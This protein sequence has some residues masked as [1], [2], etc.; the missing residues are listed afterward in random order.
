MLKFSK[1]VWNKEAYFNL[2][3]KENKTILPKRFQDCPDVVKE[4]ALNE[5]LLSNAY[6][7]HTFRDDWF[8]EYYSHLEDKFKC[9]GFC[10]TTYYN[11][12]TRSNSKIVK[13][14]FTDYTRGIPEHFGCL[15]SMMDWLRKTLNAF[16][17]CGIF[18]FVFEMV[19]FVL[20]CMMLCNKEVK[21]KVKEKSKQDKQQEED[22]AILKAR[23]MRKEEERQKKLEKEE[24]ERKRKEEEE[25]KKK[26]QENQ[27]MNTSYVPPQSQKNEEDI[28]FNPSKV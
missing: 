27:L 20:G 13:Y 1:E 14:L 2:W 16:A 8:Q 9:T 10:G 15:S 21:G 5:Y 19:L 12:K 23:K 26:D 4:Q 25:K 17:S 28:R 6:Y 7:N 22:E 18:L 3:E 24:A 11:G